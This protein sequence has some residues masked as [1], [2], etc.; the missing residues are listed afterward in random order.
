MD[1]IIVNLIGGVGNQM[2]QYALGYVVS[3]I[4]GFELCVDLSSYEN[5]K[6]RNFELN[7]F[8]IDIKLAEKYECDLLNRKHFFKKTLYKDK[9][10]IFYR[11]VLKIKHSAYLKG[12]WQSEKYFAD[13]KDDIF[14]LFEFKDKN[15]I[16]NQDLLED[17]KNSNAVSI[18]LRLGDYINNNENK[19][20]H[21]VCKKDYYSNALKYI[22]QKVDNPKY[23]VFSDDIDGSKEFLPQG[24]DFVYANTANWQEDMYFMTQAKHNI[25]A[26]SSF[27]WWAAWLNKN[28]DKIVLAPDKWYTKAAKINDKDVVPESWVKIKV[29]S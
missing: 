21:F 17:I 23:F 19:R 16:V 13:F 15:F 18:N 29:S 26:N 1:K 2:F 24:Y 28:L 22:S 8:N 6:V 11:N 14:S 27:S 20:I 12:F 25:V 10:K 5:Y 7:K 4:T 3:K 9:K